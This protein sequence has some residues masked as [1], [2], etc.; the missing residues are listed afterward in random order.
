MC[1]CSGHTFGHTALP[2]AQ[3][4]QGGVPAVQAD[5]ENIALFAAV[6]AVVYCLLESAPMQ[7]AS[8][9]LQGQSLQR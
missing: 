9:A 1:A 7:Q 5:I 3:P 2:S 8:S 4:V 6:F